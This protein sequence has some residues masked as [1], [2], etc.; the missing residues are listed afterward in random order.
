[1]EYGEQDLKQALDINSGATINSENY[2]IIL[3]NMLCAMNFI[4]SANIIHRDIK[5]SNILLNNDSSIKIADF[6]MS[7]VA[8]RLE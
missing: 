7:R 8:P 2:K 3:Y 6:N 1:M 5:P 4:H